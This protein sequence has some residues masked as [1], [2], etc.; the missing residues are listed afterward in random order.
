[1]VSRGEGLP[2]HVHGWLT[3]MSGTGMSG[4]HRRPIGMPPPTPPNGR[5]GA[6][7]NKHQG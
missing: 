1:M 6:L 4:P 7:I 3:E 5:P 2:P